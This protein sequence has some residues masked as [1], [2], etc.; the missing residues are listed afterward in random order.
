MRHANVAAM[1][2]PEAGHKFWRETMKAFAFA[3]AM[4][5]KVV[6]VVILP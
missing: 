6:S 3:F 1:A 5:K 4:T 2:A